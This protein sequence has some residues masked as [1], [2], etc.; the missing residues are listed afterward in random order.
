[1]PDLPGAGLLPGR[2]PAQA[3]G[4]WGGRPGSHG[5]PQ[6][7]GQPKGEQKPEGEPEP[8]DEPEP[9]EGTT[10]PDDAHAQAALQQP[11]L[12]A[13]SPPVAAQNPLVE[14][15]TPSAWQPSLTAESLAGW[16]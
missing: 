3:D 16:S 13:F 7:S 15:S 8:E 11:F 6:A 9:E 14:M 10:V 12:K 2:R 4:H 5:A 1:M